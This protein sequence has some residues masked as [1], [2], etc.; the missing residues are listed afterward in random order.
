LIKRNTKESKVIAGEC[1]RAQIDCGYTGT[2]GGGACTV[3]EEN[4][5]KIK[6][7]L[8]GK[9]EGGESTDYKGEKITLKYGKGNQT[10]LLERKV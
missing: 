4:W 1:K 9:G 3:N 5:N 6:D 8:T 2:G 10:F 7:S